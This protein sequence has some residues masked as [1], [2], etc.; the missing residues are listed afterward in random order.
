MAAQITR[1]IDGA[2]QRVVG[3]VQGALESAQRLALMLAPLAAKYPE[4]ELVLSRHD[5]GATKGLA[6]T[7]HFVSDHYLSCI[8]MK[9]AALV[10][11]RFGWYCAALLG[12]MHDPKQ[13]LREVRWDLLE[14]H[15]DAK[16]LLRR[17]R[18]TRELLF[19]LGA[20]APVSLTGLL[21]LLP[22]SGRTQVAA[23]LQECEAAGLV[24]RTAQLGGA[25]DVFAVGPAI[26]T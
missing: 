2:L 23:A 14:I 10:E 25:E 21:A 15:E 26:Q 13:A 1:R 11:Q 16:P 19:L 6:E 20:V 24:M 12:I 4:V 7:A 3:N 22:S 5:W 9:D 17:D 18:E 8:Q